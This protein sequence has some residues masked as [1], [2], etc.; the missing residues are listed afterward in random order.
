MVPD[1]LS[2]IIPPSLRKQTLVLIPASVPSPALPPPPVNRE[3]QA[4]AA[5]LLT[6]AMDARTVSLNK[7]GRLVFRASIQVNAEC[8]QPIWVFIYGLKNTS[9]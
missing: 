3:P 2:P 6:A 8:V 4:A 9:G 1:S 5:H 7:L